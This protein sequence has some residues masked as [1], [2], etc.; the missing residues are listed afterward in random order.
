MKLINVLTLVTSLNLVYCSAPIKF[1]SNDKVVCY[2]VEN[3]GKNQLVTMESKG[4]IGYMAF[5]VGTGMFNADI[6]IGFFNSKGEPVVSV[7]K[8]EDY[9]HPEALEDQ[10]SISINKSL[11]KMNNGQTISF[12]INT[13][14]KALKSVAIEGENKFLWAY[15][16]K[17][18]K[19]ENFNARIAKHDNR[20]VFAG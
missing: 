3:K 11:T 4:K 16:A 8:S 10:S 7:R 2:S 19:G 17:V 15:S 14:G 9:A 13:E 18:P 20:G 6:Y 5:G 1:C 12:I